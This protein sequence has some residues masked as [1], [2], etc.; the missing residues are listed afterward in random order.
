VLRIWR[1][2]QNFATFCCKRCGESGYARDGSIARL[3]SEIIARARRESV[4]REQIAK[5]E[6]LSKAR[7]LWS[8][9][10]PIAGSIAENY[11]R[12]ARSIAVDSLPATLGFLPVRGEY[13]PAMIAAFGIATEPQPGELA[14]ADSV[15]HGVHI[16]RLAPDGSAK[17]GGD[18]DKIVIGMSN[19]TPIVLV[20]ANDL[21]GLAITEGIEDALS[22]H[23]A[24]GFGA[25]AAG[26]ASR[27]PAL[28]DA[29]PR[30]IDCISILI[31]DDAAGRT[32]AA[33]LADRAMQRGFDVRSVAFAN[34]PQRAA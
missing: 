23:A 15:V 25:W 4:E 8:K 29:I 20:P 34:A 24:T 10:Q 2:D 18:T 19:G 16:T 5:A 33:T 21:H 9:R 27:L 31:D 26:S 22:V 32:N 30:Y 3:D 28:A 7:W 6:R 14:I 12:K 17:A 11:L 1:V 13:A